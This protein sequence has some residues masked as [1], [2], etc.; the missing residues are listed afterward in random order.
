MAREYSLEKTRNIGISAHIDA[1]KTTT[2]ERILFYT[3]KV[4]KIGEVHDGAATMD[5]MPQEQ[6]RGITITAACT[7]C[8][9]KG[10]R[11]NIIDTPGHVDFTMEVE[12]S[13][14]VLDG[15]V[16]VFDS[17]AGVEPQ[18][19]TVWR[20]AERYGVP[21][22]TFVNKMDR[23]GADFF[24]TVLQ[25]KD[26]L[27][28]HAIPIQLPLGVEDTFKGLIDLVKMKAI[29][30][31]EESKGVK[32][33][34]VDIPNEYLEQAKEWHHKMIEGLAE[35]DESILEK[36]VE[37]VEPSV[38]EVKSAMRRA[39]IAAKVFPVLCG[40]AF[41][42]KGVQQILDAAIDYLPT[43]LDKPPVKGTHPK[44]GEPILRLTSDDQ[45]FS[46]L[47]FKIMSD[48]Y[49]GKLTYFRVYS[50]VL[51]KGSYVYNSNTN[52]RERVG[53]LLRMHANHQEDVDEVCSGDIVAAVGIKETITGQTICTEDSPV[54][55]E[56]M[57]FPEPVIS[58]AIEPKT[59]AD[60]DKLSTALGRL[61]EE[62]PTFR[63]TSNPETGQTI[64]S[65]MG[66]LHLDVL[67]DRMFREFKVQA[68]VGAP[69]V[70]YRET[71]E[72][73]SE[74]E[75][76]Y[77]RQTG[78]RGQYGHAV[79]EIEPLERGKGLEFVDKIVGGS[80]PREYI[81]S[82]ET[83]IR[84]A[85]K[86]GILAG[87]PVVDIRVTLVDG[88]FHEVDS[89][90][91]AFQIAGSY[92]FKDAVKKASPILLEPIMK[93]DVTTPEDFLGDIIG[94]LNS[95]RGRINDIETR[96]KAK[97][98]HSDVPLSEMFGYATATRSLTKGRASYSME[99]SHFEKV[100]KNILE[101]VVSK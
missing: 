58:M 89:S 95:R 79:I 18:S 21:R 75:G 77:I 9:W 55:L 65:G 12:R 41:K 38:E 85:A 82:V 53:R 61:S 93:V 92:A 56:S 24:S 78:G 46:A 66:E 23:V 39:C 101:K 76:K 6:E 4:H 90:D 62:D 25:M 8:F 86:G 60:R 94:D 83:G 73:A 20:Q 91:I 48:P 59:Q 34:E 49:V 37:G 7:T 2:T 68:N 97:I 22:I 29:I 69:Q 47:A 40:S 35:E 3:G 71:I 81:S 88:S 5:W 33:D 45:P 70:A 80:I 54:V 26:K 16:I 87:S 10:M 36:F 17:V 98:I 28:A 74:A 43:P 67:R 31:D 27:G 15:A 64:I 11:I 1:G 51:A 57:H 42:N 50:G 32:F 44:T 96:A 19:E 52:R 63:V 13:L 30:F 14:R 100:P 99:P 72:R 84:N